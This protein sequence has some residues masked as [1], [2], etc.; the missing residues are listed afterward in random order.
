MIMPAPT[1]SPHVRQ[2]SPLK[3]KAPSTTVVSTPTQAKEP[4]ATIAA[5]G[6]P[7]T[8]ATIESTSEGEDDSEPLNLANALDWIQFDDVERPAELEQQIPESGKTTGSVLIATTEQ[9]TEGKVEEANVC[10]DVRDILAG[11]Y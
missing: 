8:V 11:L 7:A 10:V 4:V 1:M 3:A 6:S 9:S 5:G 2:R